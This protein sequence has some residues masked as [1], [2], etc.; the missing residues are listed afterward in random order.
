M[1]R[2][3]YDDFHCLPMKL[4]NSFKRVEKNTLYFLLLSKFSSTLECFKCF[5][6][7]KKLIPIYYFMNSY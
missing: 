4:K 7:L 3:I 2:V 1:Q 6:E 5:K